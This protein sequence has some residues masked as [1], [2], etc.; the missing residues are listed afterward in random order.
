MIV[1]GIDC[2]TKW[3]NVGVASNGEVLA[4]VNLELGRSQSSRLPSLVAQ[5]LDEAKIA[6][7]DIELVAVANGP[8]YYTGI[9]TGVAYAAALAE[10]LKIEAVALSTLELFV[11]DLRT[12]ARP[13][14]P[15]IKAKQD[16]VYAAVYVSDGDMLTAALQPCFIG[17]KELAAELS[18]FPQALIVGADAANYPEVECL[19]NQKERRYSGFGG[20]A[21]LLGELYSSCRQSPRLLRG[22]YLR[23]PDIGP[24]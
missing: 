5:T 13:L 21:A 17:S 19:P 23:A 16:K 4:E 12:L 18:N 11:F 6:I 8:G 2:S 9:R 10:A 15:I 3:T 7:T 24:G 20:Q 22:N 1:L 14:A